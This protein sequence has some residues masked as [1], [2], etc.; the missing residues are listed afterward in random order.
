MLSI[1]L[2]KRA[3]VL[4]AAVHAILTCVNEIQAKA[5]QEKYFSMRSDSQ[6]AL[7]VLQAV[8]TTSPLVR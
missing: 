5:R 1:S 6:A 8:K 7:K 3:T 4:Q 2:E